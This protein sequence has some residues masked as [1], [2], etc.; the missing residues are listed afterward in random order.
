M[1][2]GKLKEHE[3]KLAGVRHKRSGVLLARARP[4]DAQ[5]D[6]EEIVGDGDGQEA[7]D[8]RAGRRESDS[9]GLAIIG[10]KVRREEE[11]DL[12]RTPSKVRWRLWTRNFRSADCSR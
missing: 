2:I 8:G 6:L 10:G 5:T 11:V 4:L 7:R 9:R 12:R 1:P 3:T